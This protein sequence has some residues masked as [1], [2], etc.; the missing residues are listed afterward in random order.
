M[1]IHG[2]AAMVETRLVEHHF[3]PMSMS[4]TLILLGRVPQLL[5]LPCNTK[6]TR[7]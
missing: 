7:A 5:L 3:L 6:P 4:L 2:W 1:S